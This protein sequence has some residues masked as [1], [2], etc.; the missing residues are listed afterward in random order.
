MKFCS[1]TIIDDSLYEEDEKFQVILAPYLGSRIGPKHG[2]ADVVIVPDSDDGTC[3][4][5][6]EVPFLDTTKCLSELDDDNVF[7][8][9]LIDVF[10]LSFRAEVFVQSVAVL[11]R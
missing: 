9:G 1:V 11:G 6:G 5:P 3:N 4:V 2:K 10:V 8:F 7:R